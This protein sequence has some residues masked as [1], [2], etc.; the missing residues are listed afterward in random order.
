[1][2]D[3]EAVLAAA[4]ENYKP[5]NEIKDNWG[6]N[7]EVGRTAGLAAFGEAGVT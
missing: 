6:Y 2:N 3:D 1:M 4:M 5:I 7:P